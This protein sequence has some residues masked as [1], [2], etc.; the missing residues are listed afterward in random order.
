MITDYSE[1][2][3]KTAAHKKELDALLAN[4]MIG[5]AWVKAGQIAGLMG[6]LQV[7]LM[8]QTKE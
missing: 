2:L 4:K 8:Q 7:Y 3:V 1:V 5:Q 6:E